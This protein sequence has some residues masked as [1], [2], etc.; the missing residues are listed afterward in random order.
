MSCGASDGDVP[1]NTFVVVKSPAA[2]R[3]PTCLQ[4][5]SCGQESQSHLGTCDIICEE[6]WTPLITLMDDLGFPT[7]VETEHDSFVLLGVYQETGKDPTVVRPEQSGLMFIAWRC[8]YAEVVR[9]R[10]DERPIDLA[11]A[12]KRTIQVTITR[13]K[14][15][16]EKWKL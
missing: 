11:A 4:W 3:N 8:L 14:A 13:L 16:E 15:Y 1:S 6:F 5:Q 7:P 2:R 9:S 12:Y 10:I